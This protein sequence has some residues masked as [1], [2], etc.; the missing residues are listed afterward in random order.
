MKKDWE[1]IHD[2]VYG[3]PKPV[4]AYEIVK[5]LAARGIVRSLE[6]VAADVAAMEEEGWLWRPPVYFTRH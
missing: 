1:D 5:L 6:A 4:A 2:A 3:S